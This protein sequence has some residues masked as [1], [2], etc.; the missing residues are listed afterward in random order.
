MGL[1]LFLIQGLQA[2]TISLENFLEDI[3]RDHPLFKSESLTPEIERVNR[4]RLL[5][6]KDWFVNSSLAYAYSKLI[7]RGPFTPDETDN[8]SLSGNAQRSLWSTG[9][10]LSMGL[11]MSLT[12]QELPGIT[13]PGPDGPQSIDVGPGRLYENRLTV[14]YTHPF[15]RN[16]GGLLTRLDYE[17]S[18]YTVDASQIQALENKEKYLLSVGQKFLDWVLLEERKNIAEERL[19][20]AKDQLE[21]VR[22]KREANLVDQ[23][24]LLRSE[25][26]VRSARQGMV[27]LESQIK[28][29]KAELAVL[30]S[31]ESI[32]EMDPE[33]DLFGLVDLPAPDEA[34]EMVDIRSRLIK[35]LDYNRERL[36]YVRRGF[37]DYVDPSLDL[38]LG[39]GLKGGDETFSNSLEMIKP[40][41]NISLNFSQMI[42][43]TGANKDIERTDLQISQLDFQIEKL[44]LDLKSTL[45]NLIIQMTELEQ[46]MV[47]NMEEIESAQNRTLEE[48]KLYQ[49]GRSNLTF[50]IQ[51]RDNVQNARLTYAENAAN[52]H[53]LYLQYRE[54]MDILLTSR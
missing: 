54:V 36:E 29:K 19:Q 41:V 13:V 47:L 31:D 38:G 10:D 39:L 3:Q 12:D 45:S 25:D 40:D 6:A 2:E 33:Y 51:S 34:H 15:W 14:N 53:R 9:G 22:E 4:E 11:T 24:D 52:Y 7:E 46:V 32:R 5:A 30:A 8:L 26:A 48:L 42:G 23:V 43:S 35:T 27:L 37:L 1:L 18:E 44:K 17:A 21:Y 16:S 28:A 50:L 20:L 49:Q